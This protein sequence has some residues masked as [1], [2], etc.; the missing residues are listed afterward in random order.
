MPVSIEALEERL[1][2]FAYGANMSSRS[3]IKKRGMQPQRAQRASLENYALRFNQ[4]GIPLIEPAFANVQE[5]EGQCVEGVLYEISKD[6]MRRLYRSEGGGAY[7]I[8]RVDTTTAEGEESAYT[9]QAKK[10]RER[11][12]PSKRYLS[13]MLAGA[14]EYQLSPEWIRTLHEQPCV[15]RHILHA[16]S[17]PVMWILSKLFAL[18]MSAKE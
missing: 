4:P 15:D 10:T 18:G 2:Y 3:F 9:F 6:E 17:K 11:I 7:N 1:L 14:N 5:A 12:L 8:I 13:L 16:I